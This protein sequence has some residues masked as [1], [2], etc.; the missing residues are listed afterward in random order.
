M[1]GPAE[2]HEA[3][4]QRPRCVRPYP[5]R[6]RPAAPAPGCAQQVSLPQRTVLTLPLRVGTPTA[7]T[8][9]SAGNT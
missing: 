6:L 9:T 5:R 3:G 8:T 4:R 1:A 7:P 2:G